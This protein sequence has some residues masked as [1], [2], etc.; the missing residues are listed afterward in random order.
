MRAKHRGPSQSLALHVVG[1]FTVHP[2][3]LCSSPHPSRCW[4]HVCSSQQ[5]YVDPAQ[6]A[7]AGYYGA[8]YYTP[9]PGYGMAPAPLGP[10]GMGAVPGAVPGVVPGGAPMVE[11]REGVANTS[12]S[13]VAAAIREKLVQKEGGA[14]HP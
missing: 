7:A 2:C 8:E 11:N 6:G 14:G 5:G 13:V 12:A 10:A 1:I 9:F 3:P 4:S